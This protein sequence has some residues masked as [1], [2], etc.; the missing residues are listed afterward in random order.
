[1]Q[2]ECAVRTRNVPSEIIISESLLNL[3]ANRIYS[4][5]MTSSHR[6]PPVLIVLM[7]TILLF[8]GCATGGTDYRNSPV[9]QAD[10]DGSKAAE[11][12]GRYE[13]TNAQTKLVEAAYWAQ[14]RNNLSN[15]G[16][17][18]LLDCSGVVSAIY[19]YAGIDLQSCYPAFTGNGVTRIYRWLEEDKLLYRPDEPAPGDVIFWDNSYDKNGNGVADDDLTHIGM[20]VSV[21]ESGLVTYV[22]HDYIS[23]VIFAR[24]YP[25]DPSNRDLNSGMRIQ[26]LGPTPDGGMTAGDLYRDAGRGWELP[27]QYP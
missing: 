3:W 16:K 21:D 6:Y 14:G 17:K 9:E 24:M 5:Y 1:M 25:P 15:N 20:V 4:I 18:F 23:G 12:S 22:H 10:R 11:P 19:W 7:A 8:S 26:S 13:L 2:R 27:S